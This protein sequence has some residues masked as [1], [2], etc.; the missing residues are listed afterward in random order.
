MPLARYSKERLSRFT[1]NGTRF[2]FQSELRAALNFL[3][4]D[5][6]FLQQ[7]IDLPSVDSQ[8]AR[9]ACLVA[10]YAAEDVKDL[11]AFDRGQVVRVVLARVLSVA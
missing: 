7:A 5:S 2:D 11:G 8:R 1:R 4:L 3:V 9:G 6:I 10:F